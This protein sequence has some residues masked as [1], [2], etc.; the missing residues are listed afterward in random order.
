MNGLVA[1]LI[2]ILEGLFAIG[3]VGSVVVLGLTLL[4]DMKMLMERD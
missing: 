2:R 4:E 3:A 1:V